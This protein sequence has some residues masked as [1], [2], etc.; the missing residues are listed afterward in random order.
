VTAHS[1]QA[2][3]VMGVAT[4]LVAR[5]ADRSNDR[6]F[7]PVPCSDVQWRYSDPTFESYNGTK[8]HFGR[9]PGGLFRIEVPQ[10]WNGELVLD[11]H[12]FV[13]VSGVGGDELRVG[14]PAI[15]QHLI[16]SGFAWATSS[17]RCN[18]YVSGVGLQDTA[19]LMNV[20]SA[21]TRGLQPRRVYLVGTSL[22]GQ[23]ALLGLE[24]FP[25]RFAG[26]LALCPSTPELLDFYFAVAAAAEVVTELRFTSN[27]T[28][29]SEMQRVAQITGAPPHYTSKGRQLANVQIELSGGERPFAQEG[30][31]SRFFSNIMDGIQVLTSSSPLARA[32]TNA[33]IEYRVDRSL[34]LDSN[35]L[36]TAVR[37]KI[38]DQ[39]LR[40]RDGPYAELVPFT[41]KIE[42]PLLTVHGTG[43]LL[44]PIAL[45][46]SLSRAAKAVGRQQWLVQRVIRT[47]GHCGF[48][49][50][51]QVR[52]F[53]DLVTWVRRGIRPGGDD[54]LGNLLQAG[55]AF[56]D[57]PRPG[58]AAAAHSR[59]PQ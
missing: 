51:E 6:Q 21:V 48:S 58:D 52:A 36:N 12:L 8:V 29:N 38:A 19:G 14:T 27:S 11:A 59:E 2:C 47:P 31:S 22:G 44:V 24:K 50:A 28:Q 37:R 16:K 39:G 53:D 33:S 54:V 41:G 10:N 56:T 26:A 30:L 23:V 18:G 45:E 1:W 15:R 43:D 3:F 34:G 49:Q 7:T 55:L 20:F 9:Y 35:F 46:Q 42:R 13:S 25:S 32:A 4:V 57:P 5:S 17:Y 40:S